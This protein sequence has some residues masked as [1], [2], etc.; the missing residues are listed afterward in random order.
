MREVPTRTNTFPSPDR[1]TCGFGRQILEAGQ[2][3]NYDFKLCPEVSSQPPKHK[4]KFKKG[5]SAVWVR[6]L[7]FGTVW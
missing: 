3:T 4:L 7:W 5:N 1:P 2:A 6:V